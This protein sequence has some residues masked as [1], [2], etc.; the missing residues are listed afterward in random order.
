MFI[1]A[2]SSMNINRLAIQQLS[3]C[4]KLQLLFLQEPFRPS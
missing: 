1:D 4:L 3:L 2:F